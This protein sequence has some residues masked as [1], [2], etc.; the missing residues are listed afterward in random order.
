MEGWIDVG[1]GRG[2]VE[3]RYIRIRGPF[4]LAKPSAL[5]PFLL[6]WAITLLLMGCMTRAG[7]LPLRDLM[8]SISSKKM[9]RIVCCSR[10]SFSK[11][12]VRYVCLYIESAWFSETAKHVWLDSPESTWVVGR[13]LDRQIRDVGDSLSR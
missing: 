10:A 3:G 5:P 13:Q 2:Q 1:I 11:V 6:N 4:A 12:A 8:G 9:S 7:I